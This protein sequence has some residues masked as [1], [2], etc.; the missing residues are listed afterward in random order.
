MKRQVC[1]ALILLLVR[2]AAWDSVYF[3]EGESLTLRPKITGQVKSLE[4]KRN[5]TFLVEWDGSFLFDSKDVKRRTT[6]HVKNGTLEIS[7]AVPSDAG[8]YTLLLNNVELDQVFEAIF[9]RRIDAP[10]VHICPL[11]CSCRS[12]NCTLHCG[13]RLTDVGPVDYFWRALPGGEM[14]KGG[15]DKRID[16]MNSAFANFSCVIKNPVDRKESDP[17]DNPFYQCDNRSTDNFVVLPVNF[18]EGQSLRLCPGIKDPIE[19]LEWKRNLDPL[20]EW[21]K[22]Q[23]FFYSRDVKRRTTLDVKTGVL[24]ISDAVASDAGRYT[25]LLNNAE[26]DQVFEATVIRRPHKLQVY[27][28][29]LL[30]TC[31]SDNCM[32]HC[33][34]RLTEV[35][36]VQF[37]WQALPGG[38]MQKGGWDR[39]IDQM[40]STI[41]NF[42]CIVTNSVY[43]KQSDPIGN[44]FYQCN[45]RSTDNVVVLPVYF[46]EGQSLTLRPEITGHFESLE[47]KRN[48]TLLVK[49]DR[50]QL[51]SY[52]KDM[53]G[54]TNLDVKTGVLE[55]SHAVATDVG[56]YTLLL[57]N[58]KLDQVFEAT[59]IRRLDTPQVNVTSLACTSRSDNC[60]L[61]CDIRLTDVGPVNYS[62]RTQPGGETQIGER[63]KLIDR[64]TSAVANFSCIV[65]NPV[66]RKESYPF[67]NPFYLWHTLSAGSIVGLQVGLMVVLAIMGTLIWYCSRRPC[68]KPRRRVGEDKS[69]GEAMN[70]L[71]SRPD[72]ATAM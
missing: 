3:T 57:N 52:S 6:L 27:V 30:C 50:C 5:H 11:K 33:G 32:L 55:I 4:W 17:I 71:P 31:R 34:K 54:R 42:S 36:V 41:A 26:L 44:P 46:T 28:S 64:T 1:F 47:W 37:Y 60:T 40:N 14:Q 56:R 72:D 69:E 20:V 8:R 29:P 19:T 21:D 2:S 59:F 15:L 63:E 67:D 13:K 10:V 24:E 7:D 65:T 16:R 38:E 68:G 49:W 35:G 62:W 48:N 39:R 51:P 45:N 12:D 22:G 70:C 43:W 58:E 23:L 61:R 25:L 9:I 18:A 53:K 66:D